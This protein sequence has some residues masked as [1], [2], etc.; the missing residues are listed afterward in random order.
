MTD[1]TTEPKTEGELKDAIDALLRAIRHERDQWEAGL[2]TLRGWLEGPLRSAALELLA[3]QP[4]QQVRIGQKAPL[5]VVEE[6]TAHD[7]TRGLGRRELL[8]RLNEAAQHR[9]WWRGGL[10]MFVHRSGTYQGRA[11][12]VD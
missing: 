2:T 7:A 12:F 11:W 6:V 9:R 10:S 1:S 3:G 4:R 8:E 5:L